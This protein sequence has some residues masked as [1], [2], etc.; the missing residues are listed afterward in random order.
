MEKTTMVG[1]VFGA[2]LVFL[3]IGLFLGKMDG[4]TFS[5][6]LSSI[7]GFATVILAILMPDRKKKDD[8]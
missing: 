1:I 7:G 2:I 3:V 5:I 4:T 8:Q 6:A